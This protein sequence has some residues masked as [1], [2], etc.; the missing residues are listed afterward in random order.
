MRAVFRKK[1]VVFLLLFLC[2]CVCCAESFRTRRL[3]V[4]SFEESQDEQTVSA[5]INDSVGVRLP[6][7]LTF[8]EGVEVN[9]L[10][11]AS[12]SDW[13]DSVALALYDG[14][15]PPP[16]EQIIDYSGRRVWLR[17]LPSKRSW[18]VQIPI[19]SDNSLKDSQYATK[20]DVIPDVSQRAV[21]MRFM[22]VMKGVPA[23]TLSAALTVSVKPIL[24][25]KARLVLSVRTPSAEA[26][27]F[28]LLVDDKT[29]VLSSDGSILISP[30]E[31]RICIQPDGY[32][33]EVFSVYIDRAK[34]AS[35]EVMLKSLVPTVTVSAPDTCEIFFDDEKVTGAGGEFEVSEG[36]HRI[37]FL[38]GSYELV[39]QL[40]AEKG[41]SYAVNLSVDLQITEE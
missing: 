10:I 28:V 37:R 8:I 39:R 23:E 27:P 40:Y 12:V 1:P 4:I 21:F 31:H 22:P 25:N 11:P 7:D 19:R 30:G 35:Y 32:R 24:I 13:R 6:E 15:T 3:S 20:T 2:A 16:S 33:N 41:K 9:V 38:M 18:I 14:V 26:A 5:G 36:E 34:T 29:A 17:P